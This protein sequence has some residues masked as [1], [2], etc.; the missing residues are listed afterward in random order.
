MHQGW[1]KFASH[2]WMQSPDGGLAAI[3]YAP[4]RVQAEAGGK[5]VQVEVQTNYPFRDTIRVMVH[6]GAQVRFPLHLRIPGWAEGAEVTVSGRRHQARTGAFLRLD[7]TWSG[8]T[9]IVLRLPLRVSLWEGFNRSAA[10]VRGPLVYALQIG[11]QWKQLKGK[12]PFADWEVFPTTPWNY[13]LQLD[14]AHLDQAVQFTEQKTGDRPFS[15][16]GV[17]VFAKVKGRRLP[18]WGMEHNAAAPPPE[19]PVTSSEPLE[20][21]TLAPYG[22][23]SLRV[24]EFP[25]LARD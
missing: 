4:C 8:N 24:T 12:V 14:P 18:S 16:E 7:Q 3:A 25:V 9:E 20:E 22:C 21:L 15:P 23:T 10:L 17:P 5:P 1:P 6:S 2:L 11:S 19:S 13:A